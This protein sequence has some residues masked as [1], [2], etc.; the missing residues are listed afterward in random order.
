MIEKDLWFSKNPMVY[1][2]NHDRR[3]HSSDND[4]QRT[5]DNLDYRIEK[6]GLQ[7]DNKNM[8]SVPL[9]YFYDL[10][11]INFATKIDM[12]IRLML[13]TEMKKLFESK[14]GHNHWHARRANSS[15]K[16]ALS[17]IP[18]DFVYKK[19]QTVP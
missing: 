6:F 4:G 13:E 1:I 9:K 18:T 3:I 14:K 8:C 7:I 5:D 11:K 16:C 17:A 2:P 15:Y 19:I 12:K 10:G